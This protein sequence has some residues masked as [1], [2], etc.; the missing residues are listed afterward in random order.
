MDCGVDIIEIDR[1]KDAILKNG[2]PF[3]TKVYTDNEISY[4]ES[5]KNAKY[6]H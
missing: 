5:H 4:C 1:I 2:E 3:L 6:Q